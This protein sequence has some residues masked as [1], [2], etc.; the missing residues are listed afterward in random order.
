MGKNLKKYFTI[1]PITM[2]FQNTAKSKITK[3]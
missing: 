2:N 1:K 3:Q